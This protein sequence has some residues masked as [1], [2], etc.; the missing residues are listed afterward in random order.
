[1]GVE[2]LRCVLQDFGR[3]VPRNSLRCVDELLSGRSFFLFSTGDAWPLTV[4][5]RAATHSSG[6]MN[7]ISVRGLQSEMEERM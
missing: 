3:T 1:V 7:R 4:M 6:R 2:V 5:E